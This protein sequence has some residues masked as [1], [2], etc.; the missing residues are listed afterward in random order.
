MGLLPPLRVTR[1]T[2]TAAPT[3]TAAPTPAHSQK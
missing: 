2:V 3:T 1:K